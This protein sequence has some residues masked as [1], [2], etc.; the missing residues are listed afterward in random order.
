MYQQDQYNE[1]HNQAP[2]ISLCKKSIKASILLVVHVPWFVIV[3]MYMYVLR[4]S[5]C[6]SSGF[7]FG[8]TCTYTP[9]DIQIPYTMTDMVRLL[10]VHVHVA[11]Y[12]PKF[13]KEKFC[14]MV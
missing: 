1:V 6:T 5:T 2:L 8:G 12:E 7:T 3:Y 10:H 4:K 11:F 14:E 13:D 9:S